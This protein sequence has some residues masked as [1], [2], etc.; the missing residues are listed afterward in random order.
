MIDGTL[1]DVLAAAGWAHV[2][3]DLAGVTDKPAF[4]DRCARALDLPDWFGR[5]WDALADCLGDLSWAPPARGRLLVVTGWRDFA[6]AA[7]RD[8]GVA[9]EVFAEATDHGRGTAG[10]LQVVLA[11]GGSDDGRAGRPG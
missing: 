1:A 5:N 10:A 4:M 2:R 3:L 8:W 6:R 7:P 9:Q 11:L